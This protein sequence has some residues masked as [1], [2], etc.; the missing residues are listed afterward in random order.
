MKKVLTKTREAVILVDV[1][2]IH[3]S[4]EK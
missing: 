4:N 1:A 3:R 2:A